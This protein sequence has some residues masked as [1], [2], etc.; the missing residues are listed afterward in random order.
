MSK[1]DIFYFK[2]YNFDIKK[3]KVVFEY[4]IRFLNK[5]SLSFKETIFLPFPV[6]DYSKEVLKFFLEPLHIII[7]ISYY[8]LYCPPKIKIPYSLLKEEADFWNIVYKK[9]LGE[10]LYKNNLDPE[11]IAKF[12]YNI[13]KNKKEKKPIRI[14]SKESALLG[15]GGGKDSIVSIEILKN[16]PFTPF[17]VETQR[18]DFVTKKVIEKSDKNHLIVKRILDEKIFQ[19]HKDG[20]NGHIP[21][22]AIFA[23][24]GLFIAYLY[25]H[26]YVIV[27]NEK[28]SNFGNI[29][30]KKEIINH[31]WSK[32]EEFE[33]LFQEYVKNFITTD[34]VYFSIL[35]RFYEIKISEIFSKCKSYFN[36]FTSCNQNFRVFKERNKE[37][38]CKKC[39]KCLFTF[40]MLSPFLKKEELLKIFKENIF[41]KKENISLYKDILGFGKLKPFDCV[42]TF[43]EARLALFLA[44]KKFKN[45]VV[46]REF[47]PKIKGIEKKKKELF[48]NNFTDLT[49]SFF[50]FFGIENVCIVGYGREG[51]VTEKYIKKYHPDIKI[52]ILDGSLDKNYLEKQ[53]NYDFAIKTSGIE[54]EKITIPYTTGTNIFFS[55]NRNFTIGITGTKGK[56]TTASLLFEILKKDKRKVRLIGNIGYPMLEVL[57]SK[58]KKDEIFIIELS[59]Y[60]LDD[61]KYSPNIAV[62]LNLFP[63]H[64]NYH[65]GV[66]NYYRAK[67]NIFKFQSKKDISLRF[68]FKEKINFK[69]EK[70]PSWVLYNKENVIS[71]IKVAKFLKVKTSSIREGIKSFKPLKHRLEFIGNFKGIDFY[72]DASGTTPESTIR[73][74]ENLKKVDTIFLG[75]EDRGY[76]FSLLEKTIEKYK[77]KNLV[78]FPETGERIVKDLKNFNFIKTKS[79]KEAV[80]FGFKN[81]KKG[82]ICLLSTASPSYSLWKNFEEKGE[83][84]EREVRKRK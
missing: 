69:K 22:S 33:R 38:W 29:K 15:I 14:K 83:E 70:M 72:N 32:S 25:G 61:I 81:T 73:A 60:M 20:Y 82:K 42:G 23:F 8:K 10:F 80:E 19:K 4:E 47:L 53:K 26:R 58:V 45:E 21:I 18:E 51:K 34:I 56:S 50:N 74:I 30:Y 37:L 49:P 13:K 16:F 9:G 59:S 62:L 66:E 1:A 68:P 41:S 2:K 64:M 36:I 55:K 71:A 63:E 35:R 44:S 39:P 3:S 77:I 84:F 57:L 6:K 67:E 28:S 17:Y 65:K 52:G 24:I 48:S 31:Q 43:E 79:I 75:G 12:P 5:K 7:G 46:V 40:L 27:G 78:L 76:N 11:I 54:K